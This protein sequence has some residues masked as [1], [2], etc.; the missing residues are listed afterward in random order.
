MILGAA[1]V[2]EGTGA[3]AMA[4]GAGATADVLPSRDEFAG[5][6]VF[7][8][9][10]FKADATLP[11]ESDAVLLFPERA[12]RSVPSGAVKPAAVGP[13]FFS[14]FDSFIYRPLLK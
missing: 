8:A 4:A 10:P 12:E 2:E 3:G 5:P 11:D 1:A 14:V 7:K 6:P 13:R 9:A